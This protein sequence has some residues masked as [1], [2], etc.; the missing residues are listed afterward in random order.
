MKLDFN[1]QINQKQGLAL[2]AQVQ[3]A[4]KLLHMTN[5]EIQEF[6]QGQFQDNP[7]VEVKETLDSKTKKGNDQLIKTWINLLKIT[8]TNP[9]CGK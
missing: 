9:G 7:F 3:Q 2:T 4:I 8:L 5:Q 6:V 1:I